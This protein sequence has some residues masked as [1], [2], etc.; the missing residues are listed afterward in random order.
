MHF[1]DL[2]IIVL[3]LLGLIGFGII[4]GKKN[5][6]LED[7]FLGS[8]NLPWWTVM[9][10]IVA[11][12][13]SVLTFISIPG[14]AYTKDWFFLQLALGY[15]FG[16][17]L[18]S[19][20]L[21]PVYFN[22]GVI[23]IYE[24]IGKRFGIT[25]QKFSS[26]IFLV[27]RV[28]ADGIRFLATAV[29]V[30]VISGWSIPLSVLIVGVVTI[31]YS[32]SGG[33]RAIIFI[34]SFQFILYLAGGL[35]SIGYIL[36]VSEQSFFEYIAPAIA[37]GKTSIFHWEGTIFTNP[38]MVISAVFG[39]IFLSFS[40]HGIDYM[41]VQRTL[42]CRTL[43]EAKKAMLGS[44]I[45]VFIQFTVFLIVGTFLYQFYNGM[46]IDKDREF[47][48][49]I[50]NDLPIGIKG[51]LLA[52][53]LSAAMSTLSSSINALAS[54]TIIDWFKKNNNLV[55]SRIISLFW[56]IVLISIALIFD[57]GD[58]AIVIIGLQIASFTYGALLGLFILAKIKKD[59]K[60]A[61]IAEGLIVSI[62]FILLLGQSG[63]AWTYYIACGVFINIVT[64]YI[65]EEIT[66][67]FKKKKN[68]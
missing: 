39:G 22:N 30:Q 9:F 12:E 48:T 49:F 15:I 33:I 46:P 51:I 68:F 53:V 47:V 32:L 52:G 43:G 36:Y 34:D 60:P 64:V 18:V 20:F 29:I 44:G 31:I 11:T 65:V 55:L 10:S 19:I 13:T 5:L 27:T 28:L 58:S 7:Y 40:S 61:S 14:L 42:S 26:F 45:V 37:E 6:N 21:L 54:S 59:F 2:G 1:I 63:L 25:L 4:Q 57:E 67:L 35:L 16:R 66:E 17:V 3:F 23:S 8:R 38:W 50:V 62:G 24:V 56:A 41:M